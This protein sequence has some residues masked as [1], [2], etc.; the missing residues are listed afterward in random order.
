[1]SRKCGLFT[2]TSI[3]KLSVVSIACT[4]ISHVLH[5]FA[6]LQSV[7]WA[8]YQFKQ[9]SSS[10]TIPLLTKEESAEGLEDDTSHDTPTETGEKEGEEEIKCDE[11]ISK[12]EKVEFEDWRKYLRPL[13]P[14]IR[15]TL[16]QPTFFA[17]H[18]FKTGMFVL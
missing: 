17:K 13:I 6:I 5:Y 4:F 18:V 11:I 3:S 9:E 14:H 8:T 1:M 12:F 7:V 15:F 10:D 2:D 16:M